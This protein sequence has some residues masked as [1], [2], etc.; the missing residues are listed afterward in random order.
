MGLLCVGFLFSRYRSK[1]E[2][3]FGNGSFS[4]PQL[5]SLRTDAGAVAFYWL[6]AFYPRPRQSNLIENDSNKSD[7][8]DLISFSFARFIARL[9]S[10]Q[11]RE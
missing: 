9:R 7:M 5:F 6:L 11:A 10:E 1:K 8:L 4:P 2:L 3:L